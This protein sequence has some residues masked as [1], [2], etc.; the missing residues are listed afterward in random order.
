MGLLSGK[1][2]PPFF[3]RDEPIAMVRVSK[4]W[5]D[6]TVQRCRQLYFHLAFWLGF[7]LHKGPLIKPLDFQV[8]WFCYDEDSSCTRTTLD[9]IQI[10]LAVVKNVFLKTLILSKILISSLQVFHIIINLSLNP[11]AW[12][13]L[14]NSISI[15]HKYAGDHLNTQAIP[16]RHPVTLRR[17]ALR[18]PNC[19][20]V[21]QPC[22]AWASRNSGM[23]SISRSPIWV[24]LF[25]G[26]I[27]ASEGWS[28]TILN[29]V[30]S[31]FNFKFAIRDTY[32]I[33]SIS[34]P[35]IS[36][37]VFMEWLKKFLKVDVDV[38]AGA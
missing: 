23:L 8:S 4:K 26:A 15:P 18:E 25:F 21:E 36:F 11:R 12:I 33:N 31:L 35:T 13:Q 14:K 2:Y 17:L 24:I 10:L 28:W 27:M 29:M 30:P 37:I 7:S 19:Q 32:V 9:S 3:W 20:Q 6:T 5:L 16:H 34:L 1:P 38:K 22:Q